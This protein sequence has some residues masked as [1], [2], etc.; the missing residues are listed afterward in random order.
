MPSPEFITQPPDG[1]SIL[2]IVRGFQ[3]TLLGAYRAL[4]NP[5]LLRGKYYKQAAYAIAISLIIQFIITIPLWI[6]KIVISIFVWVFSSSG[7]SEWGERATRVA[8][9]IDFIESYV[10]NLSGLLIGLMRYLR[11]EMDEMFMES[12]RFIDQVYFRM[13][14]MQAVLPETTPTE[15]AK[16][17]NVNTV[18]SSRYYAPLSLYSTSSARM[19][20]AARAPSTGAAG[21]REYVPMQNNAAKFVSRYFRR[22]I[23]SVAIYFLSLIPY[24]GKIVLQV[25]SFYSFRKTVGVVPAVV[26]F[27]TATLVPKKWLTIFLA[28]YWGSRSLTRELLIP[29][30]ARIPFTPKQRDA[31]YHA[32]EGVL[33]GFGFGFYF[34]LK[35]PFVGVLLYGIAEASTAYLV[36]KISDPPPPPTK[37][38][39][40]TETQTE[41]SRRKRM[42]DGEILQSEGFAPIIGEAA[43]LPGGFTKEEKK[44]K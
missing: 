26:V 38:L 39:D 23:L 9:R 6:V 15:A 20:S 43:S 37:V 17:V 40:W 29:Y 27:G 30:F 41:W 44:A 2:S 5:D 25:I 36:T 21:D 22:S 8:N 1:F 24:L 14:P 33:F 18:P 7:D 12:L 19:L 4:Q 42:I 11:P 28:A 35:I 34:I 16:E 13:H 32:R 31:W 10:I 3:L